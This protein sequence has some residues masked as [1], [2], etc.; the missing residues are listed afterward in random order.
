MKG[1]TIPAAMEAHIMDE[2]HPLAAVRL[3]SCAL[4]I[5][6]VFH[7]LCLSSVDEPHPLAAA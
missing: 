6:S 1:V 7:R 5:S 4:P 3:Q 2:P